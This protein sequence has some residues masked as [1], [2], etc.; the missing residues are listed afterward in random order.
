M[1]LGYIIIALTV[2]SVG[3]IFLAGGLLFLDNS[4]LEKVSSHLLTLAGGTLLGAAF[5]GMLPKAIKTAGNSETI[6]GLTLTGIIVFF[7]LEKLILWRTCEN[8][9]CERHNNATAPLILIG[10]ALHNFI[11]GVI[12]VAAFFTS[13]KFGIIV[14]LTVIAHEI[15]QELADFGVL[16]SNGYS[17]IKAL[18]FNLLSGATTY[19]GGLLAYFTLEAANKLIPYV[20][21]FSAASFIYISLADLVPQ[22]H[23]KT[24]FKDSLAQ[25]SLILTGVIIIYIIRKI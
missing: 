24:N 12:I 19:L 5:L 17:K 25:V 18:T 20:L 3:S 16:I 1:F 8:K 11:D 9:N 10:D 15:P 6:L 4:K 21:A 7:M 23:R 22:M 13:Y 2:G 14:T